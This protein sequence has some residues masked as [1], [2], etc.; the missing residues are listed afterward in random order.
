MK[1]VKGYYKDFGGQYVSELLVPALEQLEGYFKEFKKSKELKKQFNELLQ[2][3]AARP[4]RLYHA[5]NLSEKWQAK[6][7]LKREDLLHTGAH[8]I[9]NT[10]GQA[11]LAKMMGKKRVIA[12]TGAGQHGVAIAT[13][14]A[15]FNLDCT[16]YMGNEDMRRQALNV[17][18]MELMGTK[19]VGVGG[20][21]G[22]LRHAVNE[23]LRDWSS[24]VDYTH[25]AIGSVV[26]P[27]PFPEIVKYFQSCIG[28]EARA[29]ILKKEKRL[30]DAVVACVGGGSNAIGIFSAFENDK[31]VQLFGA[32]AGGYSMKDGEHSAAL[33]KGTPGILEG[34]LSY[35]LQTRDGQIND[36]HSVSAGLTFPGVGPEHSYF[37]KYGVATYDA[38]NDKE[39]LKSFQLLSQFEGIVPALES[40]HALAMGE[41]V[42][43]QLKKTIKKP[44]VIINLSGRGDKDV[45]EVQR[46]LKQQ[47]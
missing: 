16:V 37:K 39:A 15:I 30:P 36:V 46:I 27:H 29:Q 17:Y 34:S 4:T 18:R 42:C 11:L 32:E 43:R 33:K 25:F 26:G 24:S 19:V 31:S 5:K 20:K 2:E 45:A 21:M 12:E 22:T 35:L 47:K 8:K 1:A 23:A 3:Y 44:L 41:K 9:N 28:K 13:A 40:S 38:I 6:I 10:L 7:Y 14:S